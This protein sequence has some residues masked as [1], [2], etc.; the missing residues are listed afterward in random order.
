[1]VAAKRTTGR[2]AL[3]DALKKGTFAAATAPVVFP[4]VGTIY[5]GSQDFKKDL[6]FAKG[7]E[8]VQKNVK[9]C[10]SEKNETVKMT[11]A[12]CGGIFVCGKCHAV[13]SFGKKCCSAKANKR[14]GDAECSSEWGIM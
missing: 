3:R 5:Q 11:S 8:S 13:Y 1:M 2:D 9:V 14:E 6:G 10:I 4:E 12:G 7:K